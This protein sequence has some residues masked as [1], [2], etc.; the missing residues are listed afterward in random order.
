MFVPK[1]VKNISLGGM[2][3]PVFLPEL[4]KKT[5]KTKNGVITEVAIDLVNQAKELP[6]A[7]TTDLKTLL[8][9]GVTPDV[10]KAK[11]FG[12]GSIDGA[13]FAAL[14]AGEPEQTDKKEQEQNQEQTNKE[15]K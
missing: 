7:S 4:V 14:E 10:V 8:D 9:A 5:K 1:C 13:R 2:A 11:M 6:P 15:G 12:S 3:F